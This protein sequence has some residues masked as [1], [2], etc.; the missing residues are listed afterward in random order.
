[1]VF[2]SS[3]FQDL[4]EERNALRERVYP[5]LTRFC[6]AHNARFQ[7]IDLRWGVSEEAG[8][9]QQA[10][11]ICLGEIDRCR[12]VTPRPNFLVLLG[13]RYGWL[14]VPARL[15]IGELDAIRARVGPGADRDLLDTWYQRDDNAVPAEYRLRPRIGPSKPAGHPE[16]TKGDEAAE[17]AEQEAWA[18][19]EQR[20]RTVLTAA[21]DELGWDEARRRVYETSA[22]DQEIQAGALLDDDA[23]PAFAF[24]R[25]IVLDPGRGDPDP[26][27]ADVGDPV[28]RFVDPEEVG[29]TGERHGR[30]A[31]LKRAL[32]AARVGD[33]G[34]ATPLVVD[35]YEVRWRR[36]TPT[37]DEAARPIT[38]LGAGARVEEALTGSGL[39]TVGAV[40]ARSASELER[41]PGMGPASVRAVRAGLDR[42]GLGLVGETERPAT[43]HLDR[44]AD[45][46]RTTLE[47]SIRDE[48]EHPTGRALD[49]D[50]SVVIRRDPHL[51]DEGDAHREFAE[52]RIQVFVGRTELRAGVEAYLEA[53]DPDPLVLHGGGGTGKTALVA[54]AVHDALSHA[55]DRQ[56]VC[57]FVG[58]TPASA[59]GRALLES[60]CRELARRYGTDEA[61]VP[62]DFQELTADFASRLEAARADRPL[63]L[64]LDSLDQLAPSSGARRLTWLPRRLPPH[65][66]LVVSTRP[67]DTLEPFRAR[68]D[69]DGGPSSRLVEVGGLS[70]RDGAALLDRWL[71]DVDRTLQEP[72]RAAVLDRF[73]GATDDDPD[74]LAAA[75]GNPLY[76]R[77]A[78]EEARRWLSGDEPEVLDLGPPDER[79][80]HPAAVE[81]LIEHNTFARLAD[82]LNHGEV[83]VSHALGYLAASRHGLAEDELVDLLSR[84][85]DVYGWFVLSSFHVPLDLRD[86]LEVYLGD[87]GPE[88]REQA[89]ARDARDRAEAEVNRDGP[90][91][92][93][94]AARA[95]AVGEWVRQLRE[96][97]RPQSEL[98]AFLEAVASGSGEGLRLP[99]VLWSRLWADLRPYLTE[100]AIEGA[101]VVDFYHREL[102]EAAERR[103]HPAEGDASRASVHRLHARLADYFRRRADPTGEGTWVTGTAGEVDLRGLS[104]LP[105]H[106]TGAE[107]WD[108]VYET[109]TDFT[110][111]E[112][113]AT[114]VAV[115]EEVD[116]DGTARTVHR[117]VFALQDDFDRALAAMPGD[118]EG[119]TRRRLIVTV[120]DLGDGLALRCPHC[121]TSHPVQ[122]ECPVCRTRHDAD[123]W[124][125]REI[126][127]PDPSC[128]GPLKVNDFVVERT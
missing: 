123:A 117:G 85:P 43:S 1:R 110:F 36:A 44:F 91:A 48:L 69:A 60:L 75:R 41:L 124:R 79:G 127:C 11:E 122:G 45:A 94:V 40:V 49:P 57:R 66:R 81:A 32:G 14:A 23:G 54:M 73:G 18:R 99:V 10:M 86:R 84:D 112:R 105:F 116:A 93:P 68:L 30:L 53:D 47:A 70:R 42:L 65:V 21:V 119:V 78:V 113:K 55:P 97:T 125:G 92:Q 82:E 109:L 5:E 52:G 29:P 90:P 51:D 115:A 67:G 74:G 104:E 24:V 96:G 34:D 22:T 102:R 128:G 120:A 108:G 8:L 15:P 71:A 98:T 12:E 17:Q 63:V 87:L 72:Q 114:D 7:A 4:E 46:V 103:F 16:R 121:N 9:D 58:A 33:A 25:E 35:T 101:V 31:R 3:T 64:F 20:L 106:L 77:L 59:D 28:R 76:L 62:R 37:A 118:V 26:G 80:R 100:R 50:R 2:V 126:A 19:V 13:N 6:A 39:A 61:T 89:V 107:D 27:A 38:D 56:V 95:D 83:L 111:L 88:L